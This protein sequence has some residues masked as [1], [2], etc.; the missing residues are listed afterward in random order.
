MSRRLAA[1][2]VLALAV[3]GLGLGA[4]SAGTGAK[5]RAPIFWKDTQ[6]NGGSGKVIGWAQWKGKNG[7]GVI[8][9]TVTLPAGQYDVKLRHEDCS[10]HTAGSGNTFKTDG[11]AQKFSLKNPNPDDPNMYVQF[12]LHGGGP[13]ATSGAIFVD[14]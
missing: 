4:A 13:V 7:V 5:D 14:G 9:G 1:T 8:V 12:V 2:M 3:L 10:D 6:C 11:G